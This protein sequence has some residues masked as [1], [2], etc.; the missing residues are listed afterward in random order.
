MPVLWLRVFTGREFA[1]ITPPIAGPEEP[2]SPFASSYSEGRTP[3]SSRC[4]NK[5]TGSWYRALRLSALAPE[6]ECRQT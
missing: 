5:S 1:F 2:G 4:R 3:I 6:R